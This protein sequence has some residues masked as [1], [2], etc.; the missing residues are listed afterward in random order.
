MKKWTTLSAAVA[1]SG[2]L[3]AASAF[4]QAQP[5]KMHPP[6]PPSV[7]GQVVRIDQAT[8]IVTVQGAGGQTY[9][10]QASEETLKSLKVGD[11]IEAK[12]RQQ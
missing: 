6:S 7:Q 3:W 11:R 5:P 12:L 1:M 8:R 2:T 4:A 10:F 9:E